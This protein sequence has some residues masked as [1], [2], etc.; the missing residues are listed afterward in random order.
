MTGRPGHQAPGTRGPRRLTRDS[1]QARH[2]RSGRCR[3]LSR[4][5]CPQRPSSTQRDGCRRGSALRAAPRPWLLCVPG[6]PSGPEPPAAPAPRPASAPSRRPLPP[7]KPHPRSP[8]GG[9]PLLPPADPPTA[10]PAPGWDSVARTPR[11]MSS[12]APSYFST[13]MSSHPQVPP[14]L[15]AQSPLSAESRAGLRGQRAGRGGVGGPHPTPTCD[16]VSVI[17]S[18]ARPVITG[19]MVGYL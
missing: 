14:S 11:S 2:P 19:P 17:T 6:H 5:R 10:H 8:P 1:K 16:Q 9:G 18:A 4:A 7:G 15:G 3:P 12:L 13:Q